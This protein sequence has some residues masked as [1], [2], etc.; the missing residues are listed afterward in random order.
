MVALGH[1]LV[2]LDERERT[3]PTV[4]LGRGGR[5]PL[6]VVDLV[7]SQFKVM[8]DAGLL[9]LPRPPK[10]VTMGGERVDNA[11][12]Q[13]VRTRDV[14]V[15]NTYGPTEATVEASFT[16]VHDASRPTIGR[17]APATTIYV[18]DERMRMVPPGIVGELYLGGPCV[19][20]GYLGRPALTAAA[21]APDP[22]SG[23]GQRMYRTGDRGR[24]RP[25]GHFEFWGRV[26]DQVKVRGHRIEPAEIEHVLQDFP[27]VAQALVVPGGEGELPDQLIAV[28]T[29]HEPI[30][31]DELRGY[32]G[33][34]LPKHLVPH[35]ILVVDALPLTPTGKLDRSRA[36]RLGRAT[37]VRRIEYS[38]PTTDEERQLCEIWAAV[39]G[40]DRVGI[41]DDFFDLGG[42]SLLAMRIVNRVG[43]D[44]GVELTVRDVFEA[45]TVHSL[46]RRLAAIA[47]QPEDY[48]DE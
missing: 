39:F 43:N 41:E 35:Q 29:A 40:L 18:L 38:P 6:D 45:T 10:L 36:A 24:L 8:L 22:Y 3:E 1:T 48:H 46:A 5:A 30:A 20:R 14:L 2:L 15:Y 28:L 19:G 33:S 25:D 37:G 34:R 4:L 31:E 26:D 42:H 44:N 17:A 12:W 21:F 9:E 32:L 11:T 7:T 23:S 13:R 27:A 47:A 16:S